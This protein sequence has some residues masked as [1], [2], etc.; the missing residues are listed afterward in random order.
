M[1][2]ILCHEE[3]AARNLEIALTLLRMPIV[4]KR[5]VKEQGTLIGNPYR[6]IVEM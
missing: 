4:R 6:Q 3:N 1:L 2:G 5:G